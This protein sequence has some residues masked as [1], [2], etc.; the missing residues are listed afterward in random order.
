ML[1]IIYFIVGTAFL[2]V[3][4]YSEKYKG[5]FESKLRLIMIVVAWPI[6]TIIFIIRLMLDKKLREKVLNDLNTF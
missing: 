2:F 6:C 5:N 1:L 4:R 3:G